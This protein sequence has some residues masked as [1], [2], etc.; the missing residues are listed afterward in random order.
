MVACD[1]IDLRTLN[2]FTNKSQCN[3]TGC[4][5]GFGNKPNNMWI[6]SIT[7]NIAGWSCIY[8]IIHFDIYLD[9]LHTVLH[10]WLFPHH[11]IH[12]F[13]FDMWLLLHVI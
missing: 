7:C 12:M 4:Y 1:A 13:Y 11:C 9:L 3:V 6:P 8:I 5:T 2:F 10:D